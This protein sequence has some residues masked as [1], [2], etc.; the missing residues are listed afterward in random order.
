MKK[1][2]VGAV[3][4]LMLGCATAEKPAQVVFAATSAYDA[5]LTAALTYKRLPDCATT[6]SKLCSDKDVLVTILKADNAAFD[7]LTSA[8]KVVRN[9]TSSQSALQTAANWAKEAIAAFSSVITALSK[10]T[11]K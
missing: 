9:T 6:T 2:L 7:A 5:A 10:E 3:I 1:I 11:T 8:Q 4:A